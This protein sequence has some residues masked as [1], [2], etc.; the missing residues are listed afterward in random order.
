[1]TATARMALLGV[2]AICVGL[3]SYAGTGWGADDVGR[4]VGAVGTAVS[5]GVRMA[6]HALETAIG[7]I[8]TTRDDGCIDLGDVAEMVDI[9]QLGLSAGLSFD[10]A[11]ELYCS[12]RSGRLPSELARAELMWRVGVL[13]RERA[14]M[15]VA[16][17]SGVDALES[18][19]V[20]VAQ[21][22]SLGA[23]LGEALAR[24]S[25]DIKGARRA[26][27]E[28]RIERA[29]IRLLVPTGALV[30]P[31]LLISIMGP[32]MAAAGMI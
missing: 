6:A 8:A 19:A 24:Q 1:M 21:A 12:G 22:V 18:F 9:V 2:G 23:P 27:V 17:V 15:E 25:R 26:E 5:S 20:S 29:P 28:R 7:N 11:L 3:A 31:A 16:R 10:A 13:T 30:L 4:C 14:L 32:L